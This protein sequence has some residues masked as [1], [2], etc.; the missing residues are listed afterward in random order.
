MPDTY[1]HV[2]KGFKIFNLF[3]SP[4]HMVKKSRKGPKCYFLVLLRPSWTPRKPNHTLTGHTEIKH[5][6]FSL[7]TR[8]S[9]CNSLLLLLITLSLGSDILQMTTLYRGLASFTLSQITAAKIKKAE[10]KQKITEMRCFLTIN[11]TWGGW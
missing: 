7:N 9:F 11:L 6:V 3:F 2:T 1:G 4:N 8:V 5:R 10:E